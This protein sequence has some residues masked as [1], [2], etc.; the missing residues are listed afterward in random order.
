MEP[1]AKALDLVPETMATVY[2]VLP[3]TYENKVLTVAVPKEGKD[4]LID[5][6]NFLDLREVRFTIK[7]LEEIEIEIAK[8]YN[9]GD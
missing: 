3:L 9:R 2:K 8:A 7:P 4:A 6:K 1:Q 5:L